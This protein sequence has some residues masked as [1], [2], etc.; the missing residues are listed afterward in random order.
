MPALHSLGD[1]GF[2]VRC[3]VSRLQPAPKVAQA[4]RLFAFGGASSKSPKLS[5]TNYVVFS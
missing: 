4:S 3:L 2:D 1:E 5:S